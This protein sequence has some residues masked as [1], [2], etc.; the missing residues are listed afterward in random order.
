MLSRPASDNAVFTVS[1]ITGLIKRKLEDEYGNITVIGE[2]SGFKPHNSGHW[3][4]TLKDSDAV[5]SC[6]MWRSFNS[7]VFF[8]PKDGMKIVV[9]GKITVYPPRG[10]YQIDV[11]TMKPAGA[12]EL[13]A[14]FEELKLKLFNEGLFDESH[15][16]EIPQFPEKIALITAI[17]GAALKDMLSIAKRRYPI[18]ELFTISTKVQGAGAAEDIASNIKHINKLSGIDLIIVGRGGGSI[19]DLWAFNEEVV[20]RAIY[21]SKIPVI[22]A[23]G[24]EVDYSISDFVADLRAP[25]PS[26]AMEIATPDLNDLL[27][28]LNSFNLDAV[29]KLKA[30]FI[31]KRNR[32]VNCI[33][34]YGFRKP[35]DLVRRRSQDLDNTVL[36]IENGIKFKIKD[37]R[38]RLDL[39]IQALKA[40]D[41]QKILEKGFVLIKQ[42]SKI[43]KRYSAF[44]KM[45]P[46]IVKFADNEIEINENSCRQ[47]K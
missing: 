9:T 32:L 12:G 27:D 28:M 17:D 45:L 5:I 40:H 1:Q 38:S 15:K 47:D 13:Q 25:T 8:T 43:I 24:H 44:N 34:S 7:S 31:D 36:R 46:F 30:V 42:N 22:S 23:V 41:V 18:V 26:A 3:Y 16:K 19:E 4:F 37:S 35:E 29:Q 6:C 21:N 20:A 39:L 2:L 14:A 10:N 33:K 11:R